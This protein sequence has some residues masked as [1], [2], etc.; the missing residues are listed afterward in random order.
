M[1]SVVPEFL[2][3]ADGPHDVNVTEGDDVVI[4]CRTNADPVAKVVWYING[5]TFTGEYF[6]VS[7][8]ILFC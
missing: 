6:F 4:Q 5:N 7:I 1:C 8:T 3:V 2:N